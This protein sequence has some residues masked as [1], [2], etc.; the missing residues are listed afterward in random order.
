MIV[1]STFLVL[2]VVNRILFHN[3]PNSENYAKG[4]D[5]VSQ[6]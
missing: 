6:K 3:K 2:N 1:Y 4:F 5:S